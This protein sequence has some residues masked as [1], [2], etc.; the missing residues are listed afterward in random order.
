VR[1]IR[2]ILIAL[3]ALPVV[4][5]G[6]AQAS[7][8]VSLTGFPEVVNFVADAG[9]E[10]RP[11][12][13]CQFHY[14]G[15]DDSCVVHDFEGVTASG[16]GCAQDSSLQVTCTGDFGGSY[17]VQANLGDLDDVGIFR[18]TNS[19]NGAQIDAGSGHDYIESG[20][21]TGGDSVLL[22]AGDD[23][24]NAGYG[25]DTAMGQAG[26]DTIIGGPSYNLL[27][28]GTGNDTLLSGAW[29]GT[30]SSLIGQ[31]GNDYL[32][33]GWAADILNGGPGDDLL[34][35]GR[36]DD[37][38]EG[39][40]DFDTV[41][42]ESRT[43]AVN[44]TFN[45]LPD[46][47][48]ATFDDSPFNTDR[49]NVDASVEKV[50]GGSASDTLTAGAGPVVFVAGNGQDT[51][52]GSDG[53]DTLRG[54]AGSDVMRGKLGRDTLDGGPGL[55]DEILYDE[56]TG[57]VALLLDGLRNDGADPNGNRR[58]SA[59]E[60]GDLDIAVE[61]A[62]A[63]SGDDYLRGNTDVNR[64]V[65]NA[66]GD[67]MKSRDGTAGVDTVFCG[68]GGDLFDADPSDSTFGCETATPLP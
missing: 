46:D 28:G 67:E 43:E 12:F 14:D 52:V 5:A 68:L 39:G 23:W 60:E 18:F 7:G 57:S 32:Q 45:G 9:T 42:Y 51:L 63:G 20:D 64:L 10:N 17:P 8:T 25:S 22:G 33:G 55:E 41:D 62:T 26:K 59:T 3:V 36:A 65:G 30:G 38:I 29:I 44:V 19:V 37:D 58:S 54:E 24:L 49:D 35:G 2:T 50:I 1:V 40:D 47:G 16:P 15:T 53:D 56:R 66:G 61:R 48:G 4:G 27:Y 21:G 6:T 13:T 31:S 34:D 11:T